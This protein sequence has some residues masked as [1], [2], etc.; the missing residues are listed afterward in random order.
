MYTQDT[1]SYEISP[2]CC[3]LSHLTNANVLDIINHP[4]YRKHHQL[5]CWSERKLS[6]LRKLS[7]FN[8]ERIIRLETKIC[9][10]TGTSLPS[11]PSFQCRLLPSSSKSWKSYILPLYLYITSSSLWCMS[12][13]L[14]VQASLEDLLK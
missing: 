11:S 4:F 5:H 8:H 7:V 2:S 14:G 13:T 3:I 6:E 1:K 10:E 9:R 12:V